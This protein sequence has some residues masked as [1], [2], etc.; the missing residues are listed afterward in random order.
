[1]DNSICGI[2]YLRR[3][4]FQASSFQ[5]YP[6]NIDVMTVIVSQTL[7]IVKC[8]SIHVCVTYFM[9]FGG[10]TKRITGACGDY[11]ES[12][13]QL[14]HEIVWSIFFDTQLQVLRRFVP[15]GLHERDRDRSHLVQGPASR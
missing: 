10:D 3:I 6:K 4:F 7:M 14:V 2:D 1:M 13:N 5:H 15:L 11:L 12:Q 9:E 8:W